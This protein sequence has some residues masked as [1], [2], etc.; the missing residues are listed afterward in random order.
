MVYIKRSEKQDKIPFEMFA[1]RISG[2]QIGVIVSFIGYVV[3]VM[4]HRAFI[5]A[6]P[7][8]GIGVFALWGGLRF[9]VYAVPVAAMSAIYLFHVITTTYFR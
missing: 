6:L 7:L 3:L 9:T 1:N 2:S 8:I 4:R 5:L